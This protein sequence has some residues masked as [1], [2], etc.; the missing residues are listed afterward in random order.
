MK[1]ADEKIS[2]RLRPATSDDEGF[3]REMLREAVSWR[4]EDP[5]PA[6][7][8]LLSDPMLARYV[9]GWGRQGDAAVIAFDPESGERVG[10]A[11]L[12]L[13]SPERPGY[14]FVD[15][16]TPEISIA[17]ARGRRRTGVGKAL[18]RAIMDTARSSGFA[19][20]SLSV[21]E[22]NPA[23]TLYERAGFGKLSPSGGACIMRA[24]LSADAHTAPQKHSLT[25]TVLEERM[26]VCRLDADADVPA[27]ATAASPFSLTRTADELSVVCPEG[28]VPHGVRCEKGWRVLGL[29][30]PFEFTE[31]GILSAVAAPLAEAGVGL[32]AVSTFD[33]DYVLVKEERLG[34]A[35]N[36]LR[37]SGHEVR[38][39]RI[40]AGDE[41]S[42]VP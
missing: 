35:A 17:V 5:G 13:M 39:G 10:A 27:W 40:P 20:L 36:A 1:A 37:G 24:N 11:W 25:L 33:T 29:E 30:G 19:A 4:D 22:G 14:G 2:Y 28:L 15:A 3:L 31:I 26:A 23:I 6:V 21:E 42:R 32:F 34:A 41:T 16:A 12:R 38:W 8:E 18:L 7:E 9:E